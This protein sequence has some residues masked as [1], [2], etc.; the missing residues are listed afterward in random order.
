[1]ALRRR[2]LTACLFLS[3]QK[4]RQN[5]VDHSGADEGSSLPC[6]KELGNW[7]CWSVESE[8]TEKFGGLRC[9]ERKQIRGLYVPWRRSVSVG[10]ERAARRVSLDD[11][12]GKVGSHSTD[13]W[14][15]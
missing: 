9:W 2:K 5:I 8:N 13:V 11:R 3:S 7:S 12:A 6:Q 10:T 14:Q 15:R 1:M 4:E